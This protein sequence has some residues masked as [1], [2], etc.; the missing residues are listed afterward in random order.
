M[1]V[2]NAYFLFDELYLLELEVDQFQNNEKQKCNNGESNDFE[3][4]HIIIMVKEDS[5]Q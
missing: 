3:I 5:L 1:Q 4:W 2:C